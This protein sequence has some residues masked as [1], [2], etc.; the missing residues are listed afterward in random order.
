[1]PYFISDNNPDCNGWAVQKEDG[2]VIGCHQSRQEAIDQMVA[3]SL[4][5]DIP[6]GGYI[7]NEKSVKHG[8]HDQ[9]THGSGGGGGQNR[10][11]GN[12][13]SPQEV[14][15]LHSRT[16]KDVNKVYKAEGNITKQKDVGP[17]PKAPDGSGLRDGSLTREEYNQ[18]YKQ[19]EKDFNNWRVD[20]YEN[21]LSDKSDKHLD[22]SKK[23]IENYVKDVTNETWFKDEFGDGSNFPDLKIG[24]TEA[25]GTGGYFKFGGNESKTIATLNISK[26]FVKN[27]AA[28]IHEIA[29]YATAIS[30]TESFE[31]HGSSFRDNHIFIASKLNSE[32]GQ[33]LKSEYEKEGL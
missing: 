27:E 32:Y 31:G 17:A 13:K 6:V 12:G 8:E 5:E 9:S 30:V 26:A 22:G 7:D 21:K 16:D 18:Q 1:M 19:Y 2:E 11:N 14:L 4:S 25:R 28:I 15:K 10:S 23:G 24:L 33:S 20:K 3:V 29:H